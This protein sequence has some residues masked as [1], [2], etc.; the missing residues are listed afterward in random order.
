MKGIKKP[1]PHVYEPVHTQREYSVLT[2]LDPVTTNNFIARKIVQ[3]AEVV[4]GRGRGTRRFTP[5]SA[6]EGRILNEAVKHHKMPLGDA[7]EIAQTA[8]RLATEGGYV[9]HWARALSEA[10][11]FVPA[12]M[13][14]T[15]LDDCYEAKIINEDKAGRLDFS[16]PD[17]AHF[18]AHPFIVVPLSALFE[19]V[20]K[21]S[22]AMLSSDRKAMSEL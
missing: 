22:V 14:V 21:K 1:G 3:V 15:L 16:S 11:P 18:L 20:W 13:V 9:D 5:L 6:W 19:D 7:A 2:G 12:F 4:P 8:A 17:V 10:R